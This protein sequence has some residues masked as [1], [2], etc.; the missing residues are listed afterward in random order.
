MTAPDATVAPVTFPE[1]G[2]GR[3][4]VQAADLGL[5]ADVGMDVSV[6]LGRARIKLRDLIGLTE[7]AVLELDRPV[8]APVDLLVSGRLLARG[9]VVVVDADLGVRVGEVLQGQ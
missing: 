8:G 7:G 9:E 6:Q 2:P 3:P 1:L 5:L 4:A